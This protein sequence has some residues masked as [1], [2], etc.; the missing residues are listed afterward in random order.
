MP[1]L[2]VINSTGENGA[3]SRVKINKAIM[4]VNTLQQSGGIAA[5]DQ[6]ILD[7]LELKAADGT[8]DVNTGTGHLSTNVPIRMENPQVIPVDP[9]K[10]LASRELMTVGS[11]FTQLNA[12]HSNS[13]AHKGAISAMS[14]ITEIGVYEGTD[15]TDAAVQ[16]KVIIFAVKDSDGDFGY[17]L[18]DDKEGMHTGGKPSGGAISWSQVQ[19]KPK[20]VGIMDIKTSG[21]FTTIQTNTFTNILGTTDLMDGSEHIVQFK[22]ATGEAEIPDGDPNWGYILPH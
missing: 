2:E 18:L 7:E 13:L 3:T 22:M 10:A 15:V 16:G 9:A 5:G 14:D 19:H 4:A 21:G 11:V 1:N 20:S 12:L 6:A 8:P 17:F